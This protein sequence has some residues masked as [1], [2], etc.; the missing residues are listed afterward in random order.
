MRRGTDK[1]VRVGLAASIVGAGLARCGVA[2][3]IAY[4]D[5]DLDRE[6][7]EPSGGDDGM[8]WVTRLELAF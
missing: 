6:A 3:D 1:L 5:N 2:G 8:V 7:R 4:F